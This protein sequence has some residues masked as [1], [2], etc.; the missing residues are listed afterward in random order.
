MTSWAVCFIIII[1]LAINLK[2]IKK[3]EW[4][5][6]M[7][8]PVERLSERYKFLCIIYRTQISPFL[9]SPI[10]I[11]QVQVMIYTIKKI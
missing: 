8:S 3:Y 1:F 9:L 2:V 10:L 4:I 11:Y 7:Y 6:Y 5:L